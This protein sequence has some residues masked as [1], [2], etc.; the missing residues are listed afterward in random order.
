MW[1]ARCPARRNSPGSPSLSWQ[2]EFICAQ[3]RKK[4]AQIIFFPIEE[5]N[6]PFI[7]DIMYNY[8]LTQLS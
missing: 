6:E 5:S 8:R 3:A 1:V 7:Y 4:F 2:K